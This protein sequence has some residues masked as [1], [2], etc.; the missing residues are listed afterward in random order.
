[1]SL[2]DIYHLQG[3]NLMPTIS[4]AIGS[5]MKYRFYYATLRIG[6]LYITQYIATYGLRFIF[7][8]KQ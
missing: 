7:K 3:Q 5:Y 6:G 8:I 1:M 2:K 4:Y